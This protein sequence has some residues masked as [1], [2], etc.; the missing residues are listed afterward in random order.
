MEGSRTKLALH[1][2]ATEAFDTVHTFIPIFI[3][4]IPMATPNIFE[5]QQSNETIDNTT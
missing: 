5:F 3:L 2:Y 1:V 4:E